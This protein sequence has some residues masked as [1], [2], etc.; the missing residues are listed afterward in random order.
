MQSWEKFGKCIEIVKDGVSDKQHAFDTE[1][2]LHDDGSVLVGGD[3]I[4]NVIICTK[5]AFARKA[6]SKI[7]HRL[8]EKSTIFFPQP[9]MGK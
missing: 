6:I 7:K 8:N 2:C 4:R 3:L 5:D 9:C 1:A